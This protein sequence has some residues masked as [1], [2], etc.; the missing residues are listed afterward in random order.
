[1][2]EWWSGGV[3]EWWNGGVVEWWS[4]GVGRTGRTGKMTVVRGAAF[5][6]LVRRPRARPRSGIASLRGGSPFSWTATSSSP[7]RLGGRICGAR[8]IRRVGLIPGRVWIQAN[9]SECTTRKRP[10]N[11][12]GS[13]NRMEAGASIQPN[14]TNPT[15]ILRGFRGWGLSGTS[16]GCSRPL[17]G[18]RWVHA[19]RSRHDRPHT[20]R[21]QRRF[22]HGDAGVSWSWIR[23]NQTGSNRIFRDRRL[24]SFLDRRQHLSG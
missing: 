2:V 18:G 8:F 6:V 20:G 12:R 15:N 21:L 11:R 22:F 16:G 19:H 1:V 17:R 23:L 7:G 5:L 3:V 10:L 13:A 9:P 14:Q 24:G 4:G